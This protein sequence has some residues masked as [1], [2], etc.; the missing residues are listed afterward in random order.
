MDYLLFI[1]TF[2][3][4]S[5]LPGVT[6]NLALSLG[7]SIGF[8]KTLSMMF[9]S[10]CGFTLVVMLCGYG[11]S[12]ILS[13]S[14]AFRI[15]QVISGLFLIYLAW[16]FFTQKITLQEQHCE[17]KDRI[18][19]ILQGFIVSISNPKA[20]IFFLALLPPFLAKSNLFI[21]ASIMVILEFIALMTY[22]LGGSM[23]RL[24]LHQHINKLSKFSALCLFALALWILYEAIFEYVA[25]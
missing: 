21:L 13:Y 19:L 15:F 3:S 25:L 6:M 8:K 23:F 22:A 24:F 7:L 17:K 2:A 16:R 11:A 20:Y 4:V 5:F 10:L 1:T 14:L 9:G 12:F 18:S